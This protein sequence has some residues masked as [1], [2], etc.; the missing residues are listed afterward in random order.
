MRII[1]TVCAKCAGSPKIVQQD[2]E[3]ARNEAL[4]GEGGVGLVCW[5]C[6]GAIWTDGEDARKMH[7]TVLTFEEERA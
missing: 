5:R 1:S 7:G 6:G 2:A 4:C 3:Q